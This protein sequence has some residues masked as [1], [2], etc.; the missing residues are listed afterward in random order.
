MPTIIVGATQMEN[1]HTVYGVRVWRLVVYET[2]KQNILY[3]KIPKQFQFLLRVYVQRLFSDYCTV[4]STDCLVD[5]VQCCSVDTA[6]LCP[7]IV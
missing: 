2:D 6:Q 7:K 5:A 1:E 4:L 3:M